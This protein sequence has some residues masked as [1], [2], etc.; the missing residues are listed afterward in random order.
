MDL[1]EQ[2]LNWNLQK[3]EEHKVLVQ[4]QEV[5]QKGLVILSFGTY[6]GLI[7]GLKFG[8]GGGGPVKPAP[9]PPQPAALARKFAN[10]VGSL[11]LISYY[12]L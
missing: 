10:S 6:D 12:S 7:G 8:F 2:N 1:L 9:E 4:Q 5:Y 11:L 3:E